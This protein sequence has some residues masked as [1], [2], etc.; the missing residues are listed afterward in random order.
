M[1]TADDP[2]GRVVLGP[3][4]PIF[5]RKGGG[6]HEMVVGNDEE[7]WMFNTFWSDSCCFDWTQM[8]Q[9]VG[10]SRNSCWDEMIKI[11][12]W[13]SSWFLNC[14]HEFDPHLF[15]VIPD[16]AGLLTFSHRKACPSWMI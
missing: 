7:R 12:W 16:V 5:L 15:N 6:K 8:C 9:D 1:K 11:C 2:N 14:V 4:E 10:N 3:N 13:C